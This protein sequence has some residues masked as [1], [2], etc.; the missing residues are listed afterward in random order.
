MSDWLSRESAVAAVDRAGEGLPPEARDGIRRD[1]LIA[2]VLTMRHLIA[3]GVNA[4]RLILGRSAEA[5][6]LVGIPT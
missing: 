3:D 1:A 6:A 5:V 4:D 2:L